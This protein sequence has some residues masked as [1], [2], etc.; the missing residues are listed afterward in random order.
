[1]GNDLFQSPPKV[2]LPLLPYL[3]KDWTVWECASG[4]GN[5]SNYLHKRKHRVLATDILTG[6]DFLTHEPT[7]ESFDCIITNPPY[8]Q[9][10]KWL[11]RCYWFWSVAVKPFAL[12]LPL[13][14]LETPKRQRLYKKYGLEVMLLTPR[15]NFET[16]DGVT[17]D[18]PEFAVAWFTKGLDLPETLN[19][20]TLMKDIDQQALKDCE[21]V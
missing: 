13:Y 5:L 8:S 15:V 17:M 16:Q 10:N 11:K 14:A 19:F 4:N 9:M 21:A 20:E 6:T 3:K 2:L 18:N 7:I 1:M 12:L